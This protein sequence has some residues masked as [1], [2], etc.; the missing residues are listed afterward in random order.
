[1]ATPGIEVPPGAHA[2]PAGSPDAVDEPFAADDADDLDGADAPDAPDSPATG[3]GKLA[4][5]VARGIEAEVVRRG[6]PVGLSLGSEME[7]RE[8]FGVSRSVLREAV[9]LV[10]HH[11]VARMR[12]GPNGGLFVTAP[13][14]GPATR[15]MVIYLEYVGT[16][17]ADLLQA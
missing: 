8:R 17:V 11:Q 9:R 3:T 16:T 12:R 1:M 6:W 7:L 2:P 14:T 13:D 10:E 5:Q 4:S 15:A